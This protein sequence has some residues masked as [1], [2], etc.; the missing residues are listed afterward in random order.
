MTL[1]TPTLLAAAAGVLV[2]I[3]IHL[4]GRPRPRRV[5]FPS[6]RLLRVAHRERH[7]RSRL[8]RVVAL[9]L[10][11]AALVLLALALSQPVT[12]A[13]WL[14]TLGRPAGRTAM[15]I[16]VSA[17]MRDAAGSAAPIERGRM[18]AATVLDAGSG[19]VLLAAAG[20]RARPMAGAWTLPSADA[21]VALAS[22]RARD[23]RGALPR[24]LGELV[25]LGV[26]AG[27]T[28]VLLSDL[29]RTSLAAE[30][31]LPRGLRVLAVDVGAP[32]AANRALVDVA[33]PLGVT[34]RGRPVALAATVRAWGAEA[35]GLTPL[36]AVADDGA[37]LA[38]AAAAVIPG[39]D[40]RAE[41]EF[42]PRAAGTVTG[43]VRLPADDFRPDDTRAFALRVSERLRVLVCGSAEETRFVRA[44]LDPFPPGD[45]RSTVA[46]E[47]A[48]PGEL[49]EERLRRT[50]AIVLARPAAL[51]AEG[52][53]RVRE[54]VEAG[55]GV[56]TFAGPGQ[57]GARLSEALAGLGLVGVEPGAA[58]AHDDGLALAELAT[59]RPPLDAFA[60]P[61]AGDPGEA[62]FATT[63][64]LKIAE[65]SD[66]AV[67]ARF[68]DGTPA[69]VEGGVGRGRALLLATAPDDAWSDLPRLPVYVALM[70]RLAGYLAVGRE[71]VVLSGAPGET[72][73]LA[74]ADLA[75]DARL[76]G[77]DGAEIVAERTAGGLR[78]TPERRGVYRLTSGAEEIAAV[79]VNLDPAES[80][81]AQ[82]TD[83]ELAAAVAPAEV[84]RIPFAAL[85]DAL[86]RLGRSTDISALCALLALLALAVDA[87]LVQR[88]VPGAVGGDG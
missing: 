9:I 53:A 27:D 75:G 22:A 17:S 72:V 36:S 63:R 77:P 34:L 33:G 12:D 65:G 85:A 79:A 83:A 81:P 80:E 67:L 43:E 57:D 24:C 88:G 40:S 46:A 4:F 60:A 54:A 26:G 42:M 32:V 14:A 37:V 2:P 58:R 50:D 31:G 38:G 52:L 13:R 44:A 70:H 15:V 25:R 59:R 84:V 78:F 87:G 56:L 23:E 7:S 39:Q 28:V 45:A 71:P 30:D 86:A 51:G 21:R 11:C 18:A 68:D 66:L 69:L 74:P 3:A 29:Q 76:L 16:D 82:A 61:G 48:A 73:V 47:L 6:L 41:L 8:Q 35:A 10:R 55:A 64:A 1:L 19:S 62:R 49:T 5:R 20:V